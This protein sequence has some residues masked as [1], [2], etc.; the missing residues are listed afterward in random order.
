[1]SCRRAGTARGARTPTD[2]E[3]S[4]AV[5]EM[6]RGFTGYVQ[7]DAKNV[8][9]ILYRPPPNGDDDSAV[10]K[11]VGCMAHCRRR[12]WEAAIV[13][14]SPV[15]REGLYRIRRIYQMEAQ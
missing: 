7:A 2:S 14:K 13:L 4:D 8:Y 12:Y 5:A 1:L 6:F 10:N 9:D 15:T 11:E 3:T